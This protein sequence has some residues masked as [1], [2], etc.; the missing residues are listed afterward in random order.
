M[1]EWSDPDDRIGW[2]IGAGVETAFSP[3]WSVKIE[4]NWLDF[5]DSKF[6]LVDQLSQTIPA[7]AEHDV[8]IVKVGVN[9][10]F[11]AQAYAPLK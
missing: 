1:S 2:L 3:Q 10:R 5:A 11:A 4:Y 7:K 8:S 9:Y 6:T